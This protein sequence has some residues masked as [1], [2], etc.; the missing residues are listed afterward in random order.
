MSTQQWKPRHRQ[1]ISWKQVKP[2]STGEVHWYEHTY[3]ARA[4]GGEEI[5]KECHDH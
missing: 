2:I 5:A 4:V 3:T 1:K